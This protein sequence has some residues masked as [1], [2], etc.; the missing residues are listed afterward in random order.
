MNPINTG[1][2]GWGLLDAH[3]HGAW[4]ERI[5]DQAITSPGLLAVFDAKRL[6]GRKFD[7]QIVQNDIKLWPFKVRSGAHGI[8]EICVQYKGEEKVFKAEEISSMVLIKMKE[9]A[10]VRQRACVFLF[11]S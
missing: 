7:D 2:S 9:T 8:P 6:I 10:Q 1:E 11:A 3:W 5:R 4:H